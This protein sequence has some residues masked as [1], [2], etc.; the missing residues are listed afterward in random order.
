MSLILLLATGL[1][2]YRLGGQS[3]WADE[4]NSVAL[5]RAGLA[6]IAAR[7]AL[8]IHPPLYYWLLH[9]WIQLFGDTEV[10]V[11]SLSA[12]LS[13]LLV[14]VIFRL[15]K[16]LLGARVGLVAAFIAAVSPFQVYYAQ[17]ARMYVLLALLGALT[18]WSA[19]ELL[20]PRS[21][22]ARPPWLL[23][24]ILSATLGL[25]THYAFPV[26]LAVTA[27]GG[28]LHIWHTRHQGHTTRRALGWMACHLVPLI[29]FLPWLPI[30]WRQLTTWPPSAPT[31][32]TDALVTA[33]RTLAL[34]PAS[35]PGGTLW[36]VG[37]GL[38]ALV[39]LVHLLRRQPVPVARSPWVLLYLGLPVG[40]TLA[41]FR[42][43]YLKFLLVAAPPWCLLLA[44][45]VGGGQHARPTGDNATCAAGGGQHARPTQ[46]GGSRFQRDI[47]LAAQALAILLITA[48]SGWA[49]A[50]YFADPALARDDYRGIARYLEAAAGPRDAILL[51][52]AGQQEVFG[53]Y[54]R[55]DAPVYPLPRSR[56]LDRTATVAQLET[57]LAG[58]RH[59]HAIYWATAE[60][61]PDGVI[62]GWLDGNAFKASD[63]WVGN[64]R[65][66]SYAAPLPAADLH[67]VDFRLGQEGEA[68]PCG[69]ALTGVQ[70]LY[71][72]AGT[73]SPEEIPPARVTPG[74]IVQI[75]LRW[76][77][78]AP[79]GTDYAVFLQ[80]LDGANH[81]VG[82][83]DAPPAM[84]STDWTPGQPVFDRHGLLI[85]PGTPPGEF[86]L[87]AGL[88][89]AA[90]G[91][92]LLVCWPDSAAG[93][94]HITL[95]TFIGERPATPPPLVTL[96]FHHP[97]GIN[98]GWLHLLGY[99][100]YKLGHDYDPDTPLQP[101]DPL[102]V[103]LTW[104]A[105]SQP[106][107]DWRVA[108]RMAPTG[109]RTAI[110]AE[111]IFPAAGA[112]YPT[113]RWLPGEVVRAQF[114]LFVPDDAGP[115]D[116]SVSL[117]LV[118]EGGASGED[119]FTLAPIKVT[120]AGSP[121]N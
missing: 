16:R 46:S 57:I 60:S 33:W 93:S 55:G 28:W 63:I 114:D 3:L 59:I 13:L 29:F 107:Q 49:L 85:T 102:H 61:D 84:P 64:L 1:R 6:E 27:L 67:P 88:Y 20:P 22:L 101:G 94:D 47:S 43:A 25:Y 110:I 75:Q 23:L 69:V 48:A 53:Y 62:E 72:H 73:S 11:R 109:D 19:T 9:G 104:Q 17:E 70:L 81:L 100:Q 45:G 36:L 118:D 106:E 96:D 8:D 30:A 51:N 108:L 119:T 4:G 34:G 95:G 68:L 78:D 10:A 14:A 91:Q 41:L 83:R 103:V 18:V 40:L 76:T 66:V 42:P 89:D 121:A 71:P 80:A 38:V 105:D 117:N 50:G 90:T 77:T 39:G 82:Q 120:E 7:T 115:S 24:F 15:G 5:A 58:S 2:F 112:D 99:D 35:P 37:L 92:R 74:D 113:S 52:A 86:R 44:L 26:V 98:L 12:F 111:G 56:P 21:P 31:R 97:A 116:Y 79:L 65:L 87:I 32:L 54:Y